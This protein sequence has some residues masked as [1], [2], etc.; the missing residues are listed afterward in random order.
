MKIPYNN[1]ILTLA[2]IVLITSLYALSETPPTDP[3]KTETLA[4]PTENTLPESKV[5][6]LSP[7]ERIFY[8]NGKV[9]KME[10]DGILSNP[11]MPLEFIACADGGKDYESL[12]ILKCMPWNLHLALI[13]AGLKEGKGPQ[14]FGDPAVPTGDLVLVY[15]SWEKDNKPVTYRIEELISNGQTQKSLDLVGWSFSGSQFTDDIDYDTGKP[16]GRKIYMANVYKNIIATWHDPN[17][18]L[19]IPTQGGL[20]V[21]NKEILPA[22][23]TKIIMTIRPPDAKETE[24]LK[25]ANAD[26]NKRIK[27][28]EL[29]KKTI[30]PEE[31]ETPKDTNQK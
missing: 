16:S 20:F 5:I 22:Q 26:Y 21:P 6:T 10:I 9:D 19:N 3:G 23:G 7:T 12:V 14:F 31:N 2:L 1:I 13:L 30:P 15:V 28:E 25:K 18:I 17:A 4:P 24:Q 11:T 29:K 27:E 8:K